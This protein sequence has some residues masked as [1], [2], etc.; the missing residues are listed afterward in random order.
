MAHLSLRRA[1]LKKGWLDPQSAFGPAVKK[2][3]AL[4][5]FSHD[6]CKFGPMCTGIRIAQAVT[7]EV[8]SPHHA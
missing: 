2:G 7:R 1:T 4:G 3:Y 8:A 6:I 5:D